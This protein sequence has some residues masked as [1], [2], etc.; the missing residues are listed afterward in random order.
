MPTSATSI[1]GS[2][3]KKGLVGLLMGATSYIGEGAVKKRLVDLIKGTASIGEGRGKKEPAD[4]PTDVASIGEGAD[5]KEPG[6]IRP[7]F[8]TLLLSIFT[9]LIGIALFGELLGDSDN[10]FWWHALIFILPTLSLYPRIK[11]WKLYYKTRRRLIRFLV[12][13]SVGLLLFSASVDGMEA[14]VWVFGSFIPMSIVLF[15]ALIP[16]K[17][18]SG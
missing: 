15:L 17:G 2:A 13:I 16:G 1:V 3:A 6:V 8:A 12:L 18:A 7:L 4:L 9:G 11:R 5:K 14:I 10:N